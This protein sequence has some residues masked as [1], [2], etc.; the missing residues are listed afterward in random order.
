MVAAAA[1]GRNFSIDLSPSNIERNPSARSFPYVATGLALRYTYRLEKTRGV[2]PNMISTTLAIAADY[3]DAIAVAR[4]A[5]NW[6]FLLLLLVL[7]AQIG[8]FFVARYDHGI[9]APYI[10]SWTAPSSA[11]LPAFSPR[12]PAV[13]EYVI[14]VTDFLGMVTSIVLAIVMLLLVGIM[15]VGRLVG[16]AHMTGAFVGTAVLVVLL[17]PWQAFLNQ[18]T[19]PQTQEVRI[20]GVLYT[21][22][23]LEEHYYFTNSPLPE[24]MLHWAR[25]VG[26]PV[27]AMIVLAGTQVRANRGLGMALGETDVAPNTPKPSA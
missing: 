6:C 17:F 11:S 13:M 18:S 21:W 7:L 1:P 19:N 3:A 12:W 22:Q 20:P 14:G 25:F 24:A 15:L 10:P 4:R 26:W 5:K 2:C 9:I 23:E 8:I 16:V 27:A